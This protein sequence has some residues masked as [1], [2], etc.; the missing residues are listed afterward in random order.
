MGSLLLSKDAI[1]DAAV[2]TVRGSDFYRT[3]HD[4]LGLPGIEP[5][6][7]VMNT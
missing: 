5:H 6:A 2:G 7:H 1:T 3:P 4:Q